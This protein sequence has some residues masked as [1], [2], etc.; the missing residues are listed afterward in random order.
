[1]NTAPTPPSL[2]SPTLRDHFLASGSPTPS[3]NF[4]NFPYFPFK[5]DHT[6]G[7]R[8]NK[9]WLSGT[10][11][12]M[13]ETI[14]AEWWL[15][16]SNQRPE[17]SMKTLLRCDC[18]L[19]LFCA[20]QAAGALVGP[21]GYTNG[22]SVQPPSADWATLNLVGD[23]VDVYSP[24]TEINATVTAAGVTA[25][26]IPDTG[27]APG[28]NANAVWSSTGL[29]LQTRPTGNRATVLMGKFVNNTGSNVTQVTI[30]YRLTITGGGGSEESGR[31]TRVYFSLSGLQNSW[32]NVPSLNNMQFTEDSFI[33]AASVG[34][35]WT[36][37]GSFF[38]AWLD[39]NSSAGTDS[40]NQYDNFS[41][42]VTGGAP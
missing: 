26:T 22:F 18:S 3:P 12:N 10:V 32:T 19:S 17:R 37:G 27:N 35:N 14:R 36:N 38:L 28:A 11:F 30:S 20:A 40:G 31:G 2:P 39:D 41:L 16:L 7:I 9:G 1:M 24:D 15:R 13:V 29:Y 33:A 6:N 34:L 4:P 8:P 42:R 5:N 23:P 25:Q 21:S